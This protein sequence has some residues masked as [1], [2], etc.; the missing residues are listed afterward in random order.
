MR[1]LLTPPTPLDKGKQRVVDDETQATPPPV[2]SLV[3]NPIAKGT[4]KVAFENVEPPTFAAS[5]ARDVEDVTSAHNS[6]M[7]VDDVFSLSG[8]TD[9]SPLSG[10]GA[11]SGRWKD[12]TVHTAG[13][14]YKKMDD[15]LRTFCA[16]HN[17]PF[18]R[19]FKGYVKQHNSKIPGDN[20]W[21]TYIKLHAHP[22]HTT[23]E[24]ARKG[25]TIDDFN[26]LDSNAQQKLRGKCW[27][28]FQQSFNSPGECQIALELFKELSALEEKDKGTTVGQRQKIFNALINKLSRIVSDGVCVFVCAAEYYSLAFPQAEITCLEQDFQYYII[29]SGSHVHSDHALVEVRMSE[30]MRGVSCLLFVGVVFV[31]EV[32]F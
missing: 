13:N 10:H 32:S 22:D 30:G 26:A 6:D 21:N 23:R 25:F 9:S 19:A 17:V 3:S 31:V 29:C 8:S 28:K 1:M 18:P 12:A 27:K 2:S 16:Q 11:T 15:L 24:L 14:V 7:D 20:P 4:R 5:S